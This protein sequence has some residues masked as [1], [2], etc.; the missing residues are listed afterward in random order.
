MGLLDKTNPYATRAS[1]I[2]S[3][4]G[5]GVF[6]PIG[7]SFLVRRPHFLSYWHV[8]LPLSVV[9][10]AAIAALCEWQIDDGGAELDKEEWAET[11]DA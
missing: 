4:I 10:G 8:I 7:S 11:F 9:F 1:V 2:R 6:A 3:A 5:G